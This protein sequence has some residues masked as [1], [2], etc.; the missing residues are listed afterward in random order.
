ME[1]RATLTT[2][3]SSVVMKSAKTT[4]AS[5]HQRRLSAVACIGI[6]WE[7]GNTCRMIVTLKKYAM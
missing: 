5:V 1:G 7:S 2:V 4:A 6:S 3:L